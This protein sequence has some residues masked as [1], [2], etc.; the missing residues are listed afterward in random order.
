MVSSLATGID[1]VVDLPPTQRLDTNTSSIPLYS[2]LKKRLYKQTPRI[3]LSL[4]HLRRNASAAIST[5]CSYPQPSPYY[6]PLPYAGRKERHTHGVSDLVAGRDPE[7][8]KELKHVGSLLVEHFA[9]KEFC[10]F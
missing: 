3:V 9:M 5:P 2:Q 8:S 6:R 10:N 4:V 7:L 1:E